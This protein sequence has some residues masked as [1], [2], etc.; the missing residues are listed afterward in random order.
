MQ[1][2]A[3][4]K[5]MIRDAAILLT[6][7]FMDLLTG[8]EFDLFVPSFSQ[9][10]HHFHLTTVWVEGLL[11]INF[12]GYCVGLFIVGDLAD[13]YGR[14]PIIL[15]GLLLFVLGSVFC[16]VSD[17]YSFILFGR[18]LQGFGIAAPAILSFLII[19]DRYPLNK[20]QFLMAMLNGSLNLA[21]GIA[22]V[23]GSF[24]TLYFHWRGNFAALLLLGFIVLLMAVCFIPDDR[25]ST[26]VD[27]NVSFFSGYESLFRSKPL[28]LLIANIVVMFVPYWIFVGISPLLYIKNLHVSFSV[29]G[30]YQGVLA[31]TFAIGSVIYGLIIRYATQKKWLTIGWFVFVAAFLVIGWNVVTNSVSP[32]AITS[33]ML[34]FVIAQIIPSTILYPL[35]LNFMSEAKGKVSAVI[36]GARLIFSALSL[37]IAGYFYKGTFQDTGIIIVLFIFMIIVTQYFVMKNRS[38]M[39]I[40]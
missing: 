22:P 27:V 7:V 30:L 38:I 19:A 11:S 32:I 21:A 12:I 25:V 13:R 15:Y 14:K 26:N 10:Q 36:Q 16:I 17:Y 31:I 1:R 2:L 5:N 6:I 35:C 34:I 33:G 3:E 24:I 23:I 20:Q 28:L 39:E 29:F 8:M 4:S 18:F 40:K 9:L 37:E